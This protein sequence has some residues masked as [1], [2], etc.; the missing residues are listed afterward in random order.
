[1]FNDA[2]VNQPHYIAYLITHATTWMKVVLVLVVPDI[3]PHSGTIVTMIKFSLFDP[4]HT[5]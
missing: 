1:M 3:H 4:N 5:Y 2:L